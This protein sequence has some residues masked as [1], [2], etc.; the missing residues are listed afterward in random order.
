VPENFNS[1]PKTLS[2]KD[3]QGPFFAFFPLFLRFE[4]KLVTFVYIS[5][6]SPRVAGFSGNLAGAFTA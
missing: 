3:F 1:G 6:K 5:Q 2:T 4:V